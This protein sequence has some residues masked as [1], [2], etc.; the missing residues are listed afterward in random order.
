[1]CSGSAGVLSLKSR[2]SNRHEFLTPASVAGQHTTQPAHL[3]SHATGERTE[4]IGMDEIK[5]P[6]DKG[7][8]PGGSDRP[9][10]RRGK[11]MRAEKSTL[12]FFSFV[13]ADFRM[14]L[15]L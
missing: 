5:E 6:P 11:A 4:V 1:M 15:N 13:L 9:A 14:L 12:F 10:P 7:P 3:Y 2:H 8:K